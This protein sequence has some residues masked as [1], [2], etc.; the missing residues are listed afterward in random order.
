MEGATPFESAGLWG[1]L[2]V[3]VLALLYAGHL[4]RSILA[5]DKGTPRMQ[6]VA[7]AIGR[8]ANAYLRSQFR[9]IVL[10]VAMLALGLYLSAALANQ[11]LPISLARAA[12]LNN[13]SI[14]WSRS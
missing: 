10:L 9:S 13:V 5:H 11:P 6:S 4:A 7:G 1:V 2:V 3:A 14:T 12:A 8:G